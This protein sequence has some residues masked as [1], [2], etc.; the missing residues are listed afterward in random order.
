ME[1]LQFNH[2]CCLQFPIIH[3]VISLTFVDK[4][5]SKTKSSGQPQYT[6]YFYTMHSYY[7]DYY[8]QK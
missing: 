5:N 1:S 6:L 8:F 2:R 4:K 3:D 7:C